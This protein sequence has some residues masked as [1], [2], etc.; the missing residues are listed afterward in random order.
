MLQW[1]LLPHAEHTIVHFDDSA[2]CVA[3]PVPDGAPGHGSDALF[4]PLVAPRPLLSTGALV[5][6]LVVPL[7]SSGSW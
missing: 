5:D 4:F 3:E 1:P 2:G 6:P 7:H